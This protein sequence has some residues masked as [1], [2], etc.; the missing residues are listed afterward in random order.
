MERYSAH[1]TAAVGAN[2]TVVNLFNPV[3]SPINRARLYDIVI[4]CAATP[5]DQATKFFVSRTTA[6]GTEGS[7]FT[8]NNLDSDGPAGECDVGVAHSVEPTYTASKELLIISL[9]QRATFRWIAAP[10]SELIIPATQ[11]AGIGI[12]SSSATGTA[13]HEVA[14]LFEE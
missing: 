12:K 6:V 7:G 1:G 8:P 2:K 5:A 14:I 4:G 11:N 3:A 10:G 9:N 13:S